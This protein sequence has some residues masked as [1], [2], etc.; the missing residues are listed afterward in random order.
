MIKGSLDSDIMF[1]DFVELS[2]TEAA[3]GDEV[4]GEYIYF[5]H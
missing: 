5:N 2:I 3:T 4:C 1:Y